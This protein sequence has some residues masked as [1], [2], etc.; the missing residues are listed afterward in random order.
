MAKKNTKVELENIELKPQVLGKVYKKKSNMGRVVFI[1]IVFLLVIYYIND[2]SVFINN[3]LG[4][5]TANTILGGTTGNNKDKD[6]EPIPDNKEIVYNV[7]SEGLVINEAGLTI[8]N[9]KIINSVLTFDANNNTSGK[10]DLS[11]QKYYL[12]TYNQDKTLLE[13]FKVDFNLINANSK[14]SFAFDLANEIYY[15]VLVQKTNDDYEAIELPIDA[16]TGFATLT[17]TKGLETIVYNF[18]TEGLREV[19]D[20]IQNNN[21]SDPDYYVGYTNYQTKVNNYSSEEGV[22]ATFNGSLNGYTAIITLDL[23]NV[24]MDKID[25]KYYFNYKEEAKV[26]NFEMTT[27]GF[28]CS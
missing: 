24:N 27:Y 9:F 1:F 7:F 23:A 10:I 6:K 20:T 14:V 28:K 15:V 5:N 16:D 8:N 25:A 12:E 18:T 2:I 4:K 17:C 13:R 3:L 11:N 22:I 21:V 19:R 26:V